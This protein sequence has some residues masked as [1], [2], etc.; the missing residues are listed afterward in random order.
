MSQRFEAQPCDLLI[1]PEKMVPP[2]Q[3][4]L[5]KRPGGSRCDEGGSKGFQK[6]GGVTIRELSP[7][8]REKY[9]F[10]GREHSLPR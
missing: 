2:V 6:V 8:G 5:R 1:R 3:W 10:R 7:I 4:R 9:K